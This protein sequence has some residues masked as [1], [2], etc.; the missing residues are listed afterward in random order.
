M[1]V[2]ILGAG[3]AG[4]TSAYYLAKGGISVEL[5]DR[6]EF[7]RDKPCAGGLF[8]PLLFDN[9]FPHIKNFPGK[10]LFKAHFSCGKYSFN[11]ESKVPLMRTSLRSDFDQ[12]LLNKAVEAGAN[13]SIRKN[14]SPSGKCIIDATGAKNIQD[15]PQAG[16]CLV[17]DFPVTEE[18]DTVYIHYGYQGIKGYFWLYPK[19]GYANIGVGAYLPQKGIRSL[20]NSFIDLLE[21][22]A[23]VSIDERSC[24]AKIIPFSTAKSQYSENILKIGDAAGFVRPG[25]GEGIFFAMLSGKIAARTIIENKNFAW[26]SRQCIREFGVYLR[27]AAVG[28]PT[29]LLNKIMKKVVKIGSKDEEFKKRF[30]KNFFRLE[31]CRLGMS[32]LKN[33]FK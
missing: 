6:V 21:K 20:Y 12:F 2:T 5:I 15:Y 16:I 31:Y 19:Q 9:E 26:Y 11:F 17:N 27:S 18:I 33:I 23:I 13:F 32:L 24:N 30:S 8:N 28:L 29:P 3:P 4:S 22:K 14:P 1:K 7:P 25:T 10:D